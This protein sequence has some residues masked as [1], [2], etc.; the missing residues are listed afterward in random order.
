M[1]KTIGNSTL[2]AVLVL[3]VVGCSTIPVPKSEMALSESAIKD[4]ELAGAAKFA[5][6]EFRR[7][8]EKY[9]E[10][11]AAMAEKEYVLARQKSDESR[12]DAELAEAKSFAEKSSIDMQTLQIKIQQLRAETTQNQDD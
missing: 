11:T 7:A 6:L 1:I 10:A 8:K 4:A 9:A 12:V 2:L 3:A 5:P